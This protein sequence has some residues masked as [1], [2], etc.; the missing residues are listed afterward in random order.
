MVVSV[1]PLPGD[2]MKGRIIGR[3]G[4]NIRV[5]NRPR[6]S[7]S[8]WTTHLRP[9]PSAARTPSG[10]K[11]PG[12]LAKLITDG[13]IHPARIEKLISDAREEVER[14]I[15]EAGEQAAYEA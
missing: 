8:L 9:S 15:K 5:S 10:A 11:S 7:T 3:N 6:G 12:A 4:R 14:V 13:R 1:V 2:E